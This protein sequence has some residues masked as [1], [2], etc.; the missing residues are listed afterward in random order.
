EK[1]TVY[2]S[3]IARRR[4]GLPDRVVTVP[5]AY[6]FFERRIHPK[7][8]PAARADFFSHL[9]GKSPRLL[10]EYRMAMAREHERWIQIRGRVV[11]RGPNG[12]PLRM[13]GVHTDITRQ[14][15]SEE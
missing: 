13:A 1:D 4:F 3:D 5:E 2:F 15:E 6:E 10:S 11:R 8:L 7:D 12:E 9:K 14:R